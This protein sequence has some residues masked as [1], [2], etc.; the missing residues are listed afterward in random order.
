[1]LV[2]LHLITF[3]IS[4]PMLVQQALLPP[5]EAPPQSLL[6]NSSLLPGDIILSGG[7]KGLRGFCCCR[8]TLGSEEHSMSLAAP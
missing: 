3:E 4:I 5:A 2:T 7:W 1:M 6:G 8:A